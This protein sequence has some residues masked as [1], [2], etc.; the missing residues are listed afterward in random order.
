M[1]HSDTGVPS[2]QIAAPTAGAALP[3]WLASAATF[4]AALALNLW[5]GL[6]VFMGDSY[7]LADRAKHL[8]LAGNLNVNN[9]VGSLI[10]PPLYPILISP[11]YLFHTPETS[12]R[13]I[14]ILHSLYVACQ[15]WPLY[16]LLREYGNVP[17]PYAEWLACALSLAPFT[18]PYSCMM[19]TEVAYFPLILWM[20]YFYLR[21]QTQG[22]NADAIRAGVFLGLMMLVR[23]AAST[24]LVA[25]TG[26]SLLSIWQV[27][28]EAQLLR[29]RFTGFA[30]SLLSFGAIIGVWKIVESQLVAYQVNGSYFTADD[31][32]IIFAESKRFDH[33]FSWLTNTIFYYLTAPL[34]LAGCFFY[35]IAFRRPRTLLKDPL[36][37]FA[38]LT[39]IVSAITVVLVMTQS[40]GGRELTWNK[41]LC[42]YVFFIVLVAIRYRSWFN[43]AQF[44]VSAIVLS[45]I[46]LAFKPSGLGCH[47]TDALVLFTSNTNLFKLPETVANAIFVAL[48]FLPGW[49]WLENRRVA[50]AALTGA[51][52]LASIGGATYVYKNAGDL[53]VSNYTGAAQKALASVQANPNTA[54]YYD[55]SFGSTDQFGAMRM[56]F[57]WPTFA[58]AANVEDLPALAAKSPQP[59]LY[60]TAKQ[61]PNGNLIGEDRGIVKIYSLN[62]ATLG[63]APAAPPVALPAAAPGTTLKAVLAEDVAGA[64]SAEWKARKYSI[65]W[66]RQSTSFTI[67][68]P[69]TAFS[70]VVRIQL[71][72]A[73]SFHTIQLT[74]NGQTGPERPLI[75][76]VF[77]AHGPDEAVFKV[78]MKPGRNTFTLTSIE[79]P[80]HLPDG[81]D[82]ALLL[83]GDIVA[84]A[85]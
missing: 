41:Y 70:G 33:H 34:S 40:W 56:L 83:I 66:L 39:L 77:W 78:N 13:V 18:L 74:A 14:L 51:L 12:F 45:L 49:L 46:F 76:K 55:P 36:F 72:V 57:Y 16:K 24:V 44:R 27:R 4:V 71:G 6:V 15:V 50:A 60:L 25:L 61:L 75:Q 42:P 48:L 62:S 63:A 20:T 7:L 73:T 17:S 11:A 47:F 37:P 32:R 52:W 82:V 53:N 67:E 8:I 59:I 38:V 23:T 58:A 79:K 85:Q 22:N 28:G 84:A 2:P 65:R 19:L 21:Y 68:N 31:I 9:A 1:T 3:V 81:R 10:Y 43:R 80:D 26:A 30:S 64:E 54:V 5:I 69:G 29:A 35:S